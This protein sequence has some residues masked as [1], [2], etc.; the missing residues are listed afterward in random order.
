MNDVDELLLDNFDVVLHSGVQGMKWGQRR[1]RN[2][3]LNKASRQKDRATQ[4]KEVTKARANIKSGKNLSD[5]KKAKSRFK[6]D[7]VKL[8]SREARKILN[9]AKDKRMTEINKSHEAKNR[10]EA[11][12]ILAAVGG[13]VL[14]KAIAT[15]R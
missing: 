10:A 11:A 13:L 1:A 14:L 7:K 9:K 6:E 2:R 15:S 4:L 5:L 3:S 8:G 12:A